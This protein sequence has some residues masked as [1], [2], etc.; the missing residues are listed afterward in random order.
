MVTALNGDPRMSIDTDLLD[1]TIRRV[2]RLF[3]LDGAF[4]LGRWFPIPREQFYRREACM[5]EMRAMTS[6]SHAWGSMLLSLAVPINVYIA[7]AR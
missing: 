5:S 6:A 4:G 3:G 1:V 2:P 7:A